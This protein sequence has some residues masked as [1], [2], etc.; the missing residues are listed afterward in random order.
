MPG[1]ASRITQPLAPR[2]CGMYAI[3]PRG[4][5]YHLVNEAQDHTLC[6]LSVPPIII[7]R[8]TQSST[9]YLSELKPEGQTLCEACRKRFDAEPEGVVET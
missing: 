8:P 2:L 7:N 1:S 4:G 6:G 3:S 5:V 9:I